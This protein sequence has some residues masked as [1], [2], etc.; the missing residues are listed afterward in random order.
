MVDNDFITFEIVSFL[1]ANNYIILYYRESILLWRVNMG[2]SLWLLQETKRHS[3]KDTWFEK[4]QTV[5]AANL[6]IASREIYP[7]DC[8]QRY[9][10]EQSTFIVNIN[11]EENIKNVVT[12]IIY[13]I[14]F[15]FNFTRC[16]RINKCNIIP[17]QI[18]T[19]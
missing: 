4:T 15:D 9:F 2:W 12:P 6:V 14:R 5:G 7:L 10:F 17:R 19:C 8:L 18:I 11:F 1:L 13:S 3:C 16:N